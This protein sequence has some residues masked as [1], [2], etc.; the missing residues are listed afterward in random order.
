MNRSEA[1]NLSTADLAAAASTPP[2]AQE[3]ANQEAMDRGDDVVRNQAR[4][5]GGM[6]VNREQPLAPLFSDDM[7][8]QFRGRWND[9]QA[10][11]VDDPGQAVRQGDELVAQVMQNLAE[12][13]ARERNELESR[14]QQGDQ[15]M[16]TE[17][18]R[19]A[20]RRYRSFFERL[21]AL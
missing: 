7:A 4:L 15:R 20:L 18:L 21:L 13:F 19:I 6:Q 17:D 10:S 3:A 14:L 12:S 1:R 9:V 11:F 8:T 16:S 5:E 2:E